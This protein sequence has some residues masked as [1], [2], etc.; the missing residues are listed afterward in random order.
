MKPYPIKSTQQVPESPGYCLS[1]D[2]D[3]PHGPWT[4]APHPTLVKALEE[5][6]KLNNQGKV[7]NAVTSIPYEALDGDRITFRLKPQG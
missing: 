3:K 5:A 4:I 2:A 6:K 1:R 7:T